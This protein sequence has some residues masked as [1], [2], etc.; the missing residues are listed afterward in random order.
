MA[1]ICPVTVISTSSLTFE[2]YSTAAKYICYNS[3]FIK[4]G[5]ERCQ[6]TYEDDYHSPNLKKM[7]G[8]SEGNPPI[9]EKSEVF[10]VINHSEFSSIIYHTSTTLENHVAGP[11]EIPSLTGTSPPAS[12][13]KG[14]VRPKFA[15][16]FPEESKLNELCGSLQE[17]GISSGCSPIAQ[18]LT[19]LVIF[20]GAPLSILKNLISNGYIGFYC[21]LFLAH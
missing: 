5:L 12:L 1:N 2:R 19:D 13:T 11:K 16:L 4:L 9:E 20:G 17:M 14:S 7:E 15:E 21:F 10:I 8:N 6:F 18:F 3:E